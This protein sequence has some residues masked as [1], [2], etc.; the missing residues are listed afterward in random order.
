MHFKKTLLAASLVA[1]TPA[2]SH[3]LEEVV[4]TATKRST[5]LQDASMSVS[6]I[7]GDQIQRS[8][9][10]DFEKLAT[11]IPSLSLRTSGPGRTKLNIRGISAATGVAPTVSYYLNEMPIQTISSGSSTSFQQAN[12]S[13]KLYD[14]ERVEVLRGPQGTL[15]GSSS[16]GGTVRLITGKPLVGEEEGSFNFDLSDTKEGGINYV[17]NGM[18]N[19]ATGDNG[20]LRVV[21]SYTDN[22]GYHDRVNRNT[23][24]KFEENVNT[25]ETTGV[26]VTYRQEFADT[27]V[28]PSVFYQKTEMDGKPNFDGPNDDFQQRRDFDAPEPFDDEFTMLSLTVGHSFEGMDLL[29]TVSNIDRE[30]DNI[31]DITDAQT[32]IFGSASEPLFADENAKLDDTTAELRLNSSN[33][34][35]LHWM[36]GAFYKDSNADAGYRMGR[37]FPMD[38]NPYGL[39]NTQDERDY[40]E[41]AVFSEITYDFGE[42]FSVTVGGRYLDYTYEQNKEDWGWAFANGDDPDPGAREFANNLNQ[43]VSD[44]D[45]HAKLTGTWHLDETSQLYATVSNGSRPGGFNRTVP[46][47][48]DPANSVAFACNRDLNALGL[49]GSTDAFDGD[50]VMNY[51][52]G[53]KAELGGAL[54]FNGALYFLEWDDIQQVITLS[55]ECGVDLTANLGKAES[56][57]AELEMLAAV[58]DNFTVSIGASYTDAELK[59][60]VPTAGVEAGD[61][62]PDVP[63][64]TA[65]VTLDYTLPCENGDWYGIASYNYVDENPGVHRRG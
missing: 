32:V 44:D 23:G 4:I 47:S 5:T 53:W 29:A 34:E 52:F 24:M 51:E 65:N 61:R 45:V 12:L 37:G 22:E 9:I 43:S 49:T 48:E 36:F 20:A 31:E 55:G 14:L 26:R 8:G 13:P 41:M 57:G 25:E 11:T 58:T 63:E 40:E 3:A 33:N 30:V 46:R 15:Y 17:A 35:S 19:V 60:D 27:Y 62:L 2:A 28:E 38:I 59:D 42:S 54:R 6:A 18:V 10:A 16:M 39:A 7:S 56:Q 1:L 50:E 21:A 64:W